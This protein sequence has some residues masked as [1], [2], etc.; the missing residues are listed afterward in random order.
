[1]KRIEINV[2]TGGR[3]EVDLTPQEIVEAELN[4]AAEA[5]AAPLRAILGLE[6][7]NPITHRALREFFLGFGEANPA[8]K[9]T[10]LYQRV[11]TIDDAIKAERAKL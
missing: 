9:A 5:A 3:T 8:F 7:E 2:I 4:T 1:M 10:L 11:K 6:N